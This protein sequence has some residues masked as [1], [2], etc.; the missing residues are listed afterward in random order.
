MGKIL[1][2]GIGEV[3]EYTDICDYAIGLSR[4]FEGQIFLSERSYLSLFLVS[5]RLVPSS[6]QGWTRVARTMES[7][8]NHRCH[9]RVQLSLCRVRMESRHCSRL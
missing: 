1:A 3:Q 7:A 9:L 8:E 2:E 6:M 5:I 4:M